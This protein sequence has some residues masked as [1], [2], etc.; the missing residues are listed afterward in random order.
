MAAA[1]LLPQM[2]HLEKS[3]ASL[4]S[5]LAEL[6]QGEREEQLD[7]VYLCCPRGRLTGLE[8]KL[9]LAHALPIQTCLYGHEHARM[10]S[11]VCKLTCMF[12]RVSGKKKRERE[13]KG[14][15]S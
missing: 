9:Q 1:F 15:L 10:F 14:H 8:L 11:T 2:N 4:F 12:A 7:K 3:T 6:S 5:S 13:V